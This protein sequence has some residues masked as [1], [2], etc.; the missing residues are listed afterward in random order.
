MTQRGSINPLLLALGAVV[1]VGVGVLIGILI[2]GDDGPS[3]EEPL[4]AASIGNAAQG[5][6]LFVSQGCAMCH[7]YEGR[8]GTD[9]PSLDFMKGELSATAIADMSGTIWNH[10]PE[11]QEAFAEEEIPFP[12]FEADQMADLVAY[13]HGG[14]PPPDAPESGAAMEEEHEGGEEQEGGGEEHQGGE[15]GQ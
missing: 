3:A 15:Q 14:G 8:G 1:L 4:E 9:A 10:V 13:L 6:E 7:S 5:R 12:E 11:M 2:E